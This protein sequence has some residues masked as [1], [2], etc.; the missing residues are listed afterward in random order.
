MTKTLPPER[1]NILH[2]DNQTEIEKTNISQKKWRQRDS[3]WSWIICVFGVICMIIVLGCGYCFGIVFSDLLDVFREGKSSTAWV[4]SLGLA[5][6][7]LFG[8]I[9]GRLTV[10]FG[11][12][13]V[14][15]F[16]SVF[17]AVGLLL[18]SFV[19]SLFLMFL[20]YGGIFG[21]G[22]S[23][24]YI[25]LFDIVPQYFLKHRTMVTGLLAMSTGGGMVVMIPICQALL[26]AY[27]WRG[28]FRGLA[29]IALIVFFLGWAL[30]P[31][32]VREQIQKPDEM[33]Q[34]SRKQW[35]KRILDFSMWQNTSFVIFVIVG[36]FIHLGHISS[37][38]HLARYCVEIGISEDL[39]AWL[40]SAIGLASLV[41]RVPGA[42]LCE[43][44]TSVRVYILA[45]TTSALS[46]TLLPFAT[47][48]IGILCFS[49]SYGVAD[50]LMAIGFIISIM[51]N[52]TTEQ[53]AQGF[54]F[55]QLFIGVASL[56]GPPLGGLVAEKTKS[57]HKAFFAAGALE[58]VG[59][60]IF[61]LCWYLRRN[62]SS[63]VKVDLDTNSV[64]LLV[65]DKVTVL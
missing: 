65:V 42:K 36:S 41:A 62:R 34:N 58:F 33:H 12:R 51:E 46:S 61:L 55:S 18:T 10:K 40:Y 19:K 54:G 48:W 27:D 24:V 16:G 7:G 53:K 6:L 47:N 30:D 45:V 31:S 49:L 11:A 17:V 44:I 1:N 59:L 14:V 4:G 9:S 52:L 56:G 5:A 20:T 28:A 21:F 26:N 3:W 50:G 63:L 22:T 39:A 37:P 32:L 64:E 8:P 2:E 57:Y 43:V 13:V 35:R 60:F 25:S 15:V 23:L 29:C 38:L